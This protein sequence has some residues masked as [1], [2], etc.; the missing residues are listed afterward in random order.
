MWRFR[1]WKANVTAVL[2]NLPMPSVRAILPALLLFAPAATFA[3]D[4]PF[5]F[6]LTAP[7]TVAPAPVQVDSMLPDQAFSLYVG[8]RPESQRGVQFD[9]N[10]KITI[11]G[12]VGTPL[13]R[14]DW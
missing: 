13:D 7:T 9:A 1:P 6:T 12:Q 10:G 8:G 5:V 11:V 14:Y 2:Y 4:R 3:Q